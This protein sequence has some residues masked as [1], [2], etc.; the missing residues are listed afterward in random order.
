MFDTK[1]KNAMVKNN[2]TLSQ[3]AVISGVSK[4]SI[5]CYMS[6]KQY[7][8]DD[9]KKKLGECLNCNFF[10]GEIPQEDEPFIFS[11]ENIPLRRAARVMHMSDKILGKLLQNKEIPIG[12]A[13]KIEDQSRWAYYISPKLLYEVTGWREK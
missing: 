1:L 13:Y 12:Y 6:G 7:P 4:S 10:E 2:I 8:R 9:I 11:T 3:L 5:S